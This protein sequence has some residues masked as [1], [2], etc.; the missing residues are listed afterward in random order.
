MSRHYDT[1]VLG[2]GPAGLTAGIYLARAR[3]K[4]LIVDEGIAG[5]Q[6]V[7]S[8]AV[9]NYPGVIETSGAMLA[10]TM[11][12]QAEAFG[13]ELATQTGLLAL[14][15]QAQPKRFE[16]SEPLDDGSTEVTADAV[17]LATGGVPRTLGLASEERFKGRGISYCATCDGDFFTGMEIVAIGGGNSAIEEAVSLAKYA[18]KVTVVHELDH[19]QAQPWLVTEAREHP[20]VELVLEQKV[21]E[22]VGEDRLEKI[23]VKHQRSGEVSEIPAAGAFVFIGYLPNT[24][25]FR[26]QVALDAR[27]QIIADESLAT[28]TA[29]V[30][31][32]GDSRVKRYRQI[33]TAVADGT[34]AALS[35]I[36]HLGR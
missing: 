18:S 26:G 27:G 14:D 9:A 1:I 36:E 24:E 34:I 15:L 6:L 28:S 22:F 13:C 3:V 20:R 35:V 30:F 12:K 10:R 4:T 17:I 29:G 11:K 5:G 33:T 25:A 7:L 21:Q 23:V 8:H 19:F 2:A 16:L 32:A 31:A